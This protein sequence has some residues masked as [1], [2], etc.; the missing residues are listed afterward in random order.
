[1]IDLTWITTSPAG[2]AIGWAVIHSFWQLSLIAIALRLLL[3]IVPQRRSNLRYLLLLSG[4]AAAVIWSGITVQANWEKDIAAPSVTNITSP[5]TED[6]AQEMEQVT[7]HAPTLFEKAGELIQSL[8][9]HIPLISVCWAIGTLLFALYLLVGLFYIKWLQ[10]SRVTLPDE[11]WEDRLRE[12]CGQMHI[13]RKVRLYLSER[14][15]TPITFQ[16]FRPVILMPVSIFSGLT[17]AQIEVLL[18]HELAHIRRYDFAINLLQSLVEIIFFYHPAVWWICSRIREEREYACD[19]AVMK[20]QQEPFTYVEALT[21][22]QSYHFSIKNKLVMSANTNP[23]LLSKRVYRL[24]GRY[25]REP[26]RY[27]SILFACLLL[28]FFSAQAFIPKGN[29][30]IIDSLEELNMVQDTSKETPLFVV[31]GEVKNW[32]KPIGNQLDPNDISA[33]KV[34]KGQQAL[35]KYG[36]KGRHGVVEIQTKGEAT[37]VETSRPQPEQQVVIRPRDNASADHVIKGKVLDSQK[38]PLIG[39]SILVKGT[40]MGTISDFDGNF[41]LR[42]DKECVDLIFS[43]VGMATYEQNNICADQTLEVVLAKEAVTTETATVIAVR[44]SKNLVRGV[45]TSEDGAA[46][47]GATVLVKGKTVGTI[48]DFDGNFVL[49]LPEGCATLAF[50]YIGYQTGEFSDV[51]AGDTLNV[52]LRTE[53]AQTELPATPEFNPLQQ[54]IDDNL[55]VF[56]NPASE[57]VNISFQLE[58]AAEVTI[59]VYTLEGKLVK[60]LVDQSLNAG[61]H[62]FSWQPGSDDKGMLNM[63]MTVGEASFNRSVL[64]Q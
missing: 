24:F 40:T 60:T 48:T 14:V 30:P 20:L 54:R 32:T 22:V 23:S 50:N 64:V 4:L 8:D 31:D 41:E 63:M 18:L 38:M 12:L 27:K 19:L 58:E 25:D 42:T 29:A 45:V 15:K 7:G 39:A 5:V 51:C 33:I 49:H 10:H 37:E 1:M 47:I 9:P 28:L 6:G 35:D 52:M 11:T 61:S 62:Q 56:P 26:V 21:Q 13:R 57:E 55:K 59:S 44:K 34:L 3:R 46:L 53:Q 17:P 36:E 2:K 43:Y 16:L